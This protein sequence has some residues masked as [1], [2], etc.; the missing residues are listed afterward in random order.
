VL[1]R[2]YRLLNA[3]I[4][5]YRYMANLSAERWRESIA[6]H[7]AIM[8]ALR[9]RDGATLATR[10]RDHLVAKLEAVHQRLDHDDHQAA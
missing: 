4:R 3:R 7:E 2:E 8:A 6:E 1:E 9:E 5:R 10:L